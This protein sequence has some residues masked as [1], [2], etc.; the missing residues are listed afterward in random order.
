[1]PAVFDPAY[2][3][4]ISGPNVKTGDTKMDL[5]QQLIKHIARFKKENHCARLV[6]VWCGSTEKY[7][8]AA[9]V[10]QTVKAFEQG[11]EHNSPDISPS[12]IYAY[13]ALKSGV[14]Y[15]NG[16]PNLSV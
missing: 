3:S 12:Q 8:Q 4:R 16:A 1:M 6:I 5:P 15:A 14:P 10:H 2:V 13:A 7:Q 9:G 11:L